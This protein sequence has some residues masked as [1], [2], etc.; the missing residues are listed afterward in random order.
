VLRLGRLILGRQSSHLGLVLHLRQ[1]KQRLVVREDLLQAHI[2]DIF[3]L[4]ARLV[5]GSRARA[6]ILVAC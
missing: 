6:T 3:A 5:E 4:H 1:M 2:R